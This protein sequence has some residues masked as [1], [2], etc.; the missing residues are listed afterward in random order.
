MSTEV[1]CKQTTWQNSPDRGENYKIMKDLRAVVL[2]CGSSCVWWPMFWRIW[3]TSIFTTHTHKSFRV[4]VF[5]SA[6]LQII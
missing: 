2:L 5:S 3:C 6:C 1:H 4:I